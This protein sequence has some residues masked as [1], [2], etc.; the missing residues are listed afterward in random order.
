QLPQVAGRLRSASHPFAAA[1]SQ[2]AKPALQSKPHVPPTHVG[3]AFGGVGQTLPQVPQL[4]SAP[5]VSMHAPSQRI[6]PDAQ[7]SPPSVEPAS[8][9]PASVEPASIE[10]A[11]IEPA[12]I[13]PTSSQRRSAPQRCPLAQRASSCATPQMPMTPQ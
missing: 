2:S 9:E 13:P 11:S 4:V 6:S 12:S 3:I 1:P 5:L 8:V 10:P 7:P